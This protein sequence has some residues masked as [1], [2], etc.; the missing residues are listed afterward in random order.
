MVSSIGDTPWTG[1][2]G[3]SLSTA[4]ADITLSSD[5]LNIRWPIMRD[6][7]VE[8]ILQAWRDSPLAKERRV[9]KLNKDILRE[10]YAW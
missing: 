1:D 3:G 2:F 8:M 7:D 5:N 4:N 6:D 9:R 10:V